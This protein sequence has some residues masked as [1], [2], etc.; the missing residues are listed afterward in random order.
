[1]FWNL[2]NTLT[3]LRLLAAILLP[4]AFVAFPRPFADMIALGLFVTASITDWLDGV[5]A[6]RWQLESKIGAM[7]DPIADKAMVII[8][9]MMLA[10]L[11]GIS[12]LII[13]PSVVIFFREIFVSGL[14][15]FLGQKAGGLTV[16][17][18]AKWKTTVQMLAIILLLALGIAEHYFGMLSYGMS[19]ELVNDILDGTVPDELS[20]RSYYYASQFCWSAGIVL[21]W[22]S[23]V[24]T[25]LSGLDYFRKALPM[26]QGPK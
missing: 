19:Y 24:M 25:L 26:L 12:P 15:E 8:T 20:L 17:N 5:I 2:P 9:L 21:L 6:R 18:L 23:A 16:T 4:L 22:L 3:V 13:I 14:R 7:L 1:M 11:Y 10:A